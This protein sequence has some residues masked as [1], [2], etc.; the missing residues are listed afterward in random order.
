MSLTT[1]LVGIDPSQRHI[2]LCLRSGTEVIFR[3]VNPKAKDIL[4]CGQELYEGVLQFIVDHDACQADFAIERQL[5]VGAQSS[6]L[7]YH[8][9]MK[10]LE[11][12]YTVRAKR[13]AI[14]MPLPVQLQS[15]VYHKHGLKPSKKATPYV[16]LYRDL[17]GDQRRLSIHCV[18]AYFLTELAR[19]V[20]AGTW[21][22]KLPYRET[23][24]HPWGIQNERGDKEVS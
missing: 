9:Q 19:E 4:T 7:M 2:G 11:V 15:Y 1:K 24:L 17:T 8:M 3:Q 20:K 14:V 10:T 13:G 6:S 21:E 22:Y 18:D 5:S 12:L 23:A 16:D